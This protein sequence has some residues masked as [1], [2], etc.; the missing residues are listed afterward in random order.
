[1]A[2]VYTSRISKLKSLLIDD[3]VGMR[4]NLRAQLVQLGIQDVMQAASAADAL[5]AISRQSPGNP[6]ARR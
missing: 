2:I 1:M 6:Y 5:K 3:M 4:A